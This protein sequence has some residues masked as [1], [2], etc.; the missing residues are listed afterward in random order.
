MGMSHSWIPG[1]SRH[2]SPNVGGTLK[3]RGIVLHYTAGYSLGSAVETLCNPRARAS[4]HFVV[5]LEGDI[6]QLVPLHKQAWHAGPSTYRGL[7]GL[8]AYTFGI[9][10][11]NPGWFK[12]LDEKGGRL[13][14]SYGKRFD[15]GDLR[16]YGWNE[17]VVEP[18]PRVGS[19]EFA[20]PCYPARQLSA[21]EELVDFLTAQYPL[22]FAV[23]HEEIDTRGWKT[24][25]GPAFPMNRFRKIVDDRRDDT[26]LVKV[27][28]FALNR[29]GGPGV[30]FER[31]G[32]SHAGDVLVVHEHR[33]GWLFV[34]PSNTSASDGF[35]VYAKYTEP[36]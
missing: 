1:T 24:D 13:I 34:T 23:S 16:K 33:D 17:F 30:E 4:A 27:T 18:H 25:P 35:W 15:C 8:N 19:G 32:V 9:E 26:D 7:K 20:W 2:E 6:A 22:L 28:A 3:P 5:G 12:F 11:V 29:R 21:V 14:D 10:I 36:V 31:V